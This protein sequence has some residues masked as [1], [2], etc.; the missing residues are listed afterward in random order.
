MFRPDVTGIP[1]LRSFQRRKTT[2]RVFGMISH[3]TRGENR[4]LVG[5][6]SNIVAAG[7]A[8][9]MV[10]QSPSSSYFAPRSLWRCL[11]G[12]SAAPM[13]WFALADKDRK[14][15]EVRLLSR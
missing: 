11:G 13:F 9:K 10:G 4:T 1:E 7:S 14:I 5:G 3:A 6:S 12:L 15:A 2:L 8:S